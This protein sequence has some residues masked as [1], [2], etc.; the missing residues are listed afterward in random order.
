MSKATEYV[1]LEKLGC[2]QY[3]LT[4]TCLIYLLLICLFILQGVFSPSD[5]EN[6]MREWDFL[7]LCGWCIFSSSVLYIYITW[8]SYWPLLLY[9]KAITVTTDWY[10]NLW[11]STH[12]SFPA[13]ALAIV[14]YL[15]HYLLH[16]TQL[17]H[18][19]PPPPPFL[20]RMRASCCPCGI[21]QFFLKNRCGQIKCPQS[22]VKKS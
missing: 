5:V 11:Q 12:A 15:A 14:H 10:I 3:I 8:L 22:E 17:L 21:H 16:W 20:S 2:T 6:S 19:S 7:W 4:V 18:S 1:W 13:C 9:A